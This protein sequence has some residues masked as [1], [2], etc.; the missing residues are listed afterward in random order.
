MAIPQDQWETGLAYLNIHDPLV[1]WMVY[2]GELVS[3]SGHGPDWALS[4]FTVENLRALAAGARRD[5]WE[6][7]LAL[8]AVRSTYYAQCASRLRG[9]YLFADETSARRA[10][11]WARPGFVPENQVEVAIAPNSVISRHDAEWISTRLTWDRTEDWMNR[12]LSGEARVD[13]EAVWEYVVDG[14]AVVYGTTV[15]EAAYDVLKNAWPDSLALLELSR[16]AFWLDW[17][18]GRVAPMLGRDDDTY[19]VQYLLNFE[20]ADNPEFLKALSEFEGERNTNDLNA[21]SELVTPDLTQR[22]FEFPASIF[23]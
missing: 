11:L 20:D 5:W 13:E 12:Y 1:A 4:F 6:G 15:R 2:R 7:E 3:A 23:E 17:P 14:S 9:F 18:L 8:E 19:R 22:A 16:L 10:R 21:T